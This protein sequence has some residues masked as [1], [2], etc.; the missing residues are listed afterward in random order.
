MADLMTREPERRPVW[1]IVMGALVAA[2]ACGA[3]ALG[4]LHALVNDGS[5]GK[6]DAPAPGETVVERLLSDAEDDSGAKLLAASALGCDLADVAV[7]EDNDGNIVYRDAND[8]DGDSYAYAVAPARFPGLA[9]ASANLT[10]GLVSQGGETVEDA[11][12][13]EAELYC[14]VLEALAMDA[15]A[16]RAF[17]TVSRH[18]AEDATGADGFRFKDG[19][20][21]TDASVG[22]SIPIVSDSSS[23]SPRL[24]TVSAMSD[25]TVCWQ[26]WRDD[27][28]F[29]NLPLKPLASASFGDGTAATAQAYVANLATGAKTVCTDAIRIAGSLTVI[30]ALDGEDY[31]LTP[32]SYRSDATDDATSDGKNSGDKENETDDESGSKDSKWRTSTPV[33]EK[34]RTSASSSA[35]SSAPTAPSRSAS[36]SSRKTNS[37]S[38]STESNGT[39]KAKSTSK[40]DSSPKKSKKKSASTA[41]KKQKKKATTIDLGVEKVKLIKTSSTKKSPSK[42]NKKKK[43]K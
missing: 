6:A 38:S 9:A 19:A 28:E 14:W 8:L 35:T 23:D 1:P 4:V 42:K 7:A 43:K 12:E 32:F 40:S 18:P 39:K 20:S 10:A 21:P 27:G 22:E 11:D 34:K 37:R 33:K 36:S 2:A 41:V 24:L 29:G 16:D 13:M 5:S 26:M 31:V 30:G 25:G 15:T 3:V 17:E